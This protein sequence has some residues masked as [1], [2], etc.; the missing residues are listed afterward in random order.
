MLGV[1]NVGSTHNLRSMP[2]KLI[3]EWVQLVQ[4]CGN[5]LRGVAN[6]PLGCRSF[7][8]RN[9]SDAAWAYRV[10]CGY[11]FSNKIEGGNLIKMLSLLLA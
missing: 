1:A 2:R 7:E 11:P 4:M 5:L 9:L 8:G 10:L 6:R 3:F